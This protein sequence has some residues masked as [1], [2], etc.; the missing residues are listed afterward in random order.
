MNRA[1]RESAAR[2]LLAQP[3]PRVPAELYG[4]AVRHGNRMRRRR[5]LARRTLWLV[6][7][8]AVAA[9]AV[10]ALTVRPWA[11]PPSQ[12]TPPVSGW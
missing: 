1:A 2:R 5:A 10:W 11:E 6:L 7:L 4:D 8:T 9:F 3:P 12:T